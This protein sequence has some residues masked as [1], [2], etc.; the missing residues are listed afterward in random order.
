M[1]TIFTEYAAKKLNIDE[2]TFNESLDPNISAYVLRLLN[3]TLSEN[4]NDKENDI[5][6]EKVSRA[7]KIVG[8]I[9][10][11]PK[12]SVNIF[13]TT[14]RVAQNTPFRRQYSISTIVDQRNA[15]IKA[16]KRESPEAEM[17]PKQAKIQKTSEVMQ[18]SM[19]DSFDYEVEALDECSYMQKHRCKQ[20]SAS[21]EA[22]KSAV[23]RDSFDSS[24]VSIERE[25]FS[26]VEVS[27]L[28]NTS[29]NQKFQLPKSIIVRKLEPKIEMSQEFS[30]Q[31]VLNVPSIDESFDA[32]RAHSTPQPANVTMLDITNIHR[33]S[34]AIVP[35]RLV[36]EPETSSKALETD[37]P[38]W[39]SDFMRRYDSDM[40]RI[41][42][43]L[44]K[45]DR[46]LRLIV[47]GEKV[48]PKKVLIYPRVTQV[49]RGY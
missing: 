5:A 42:N 30:N 49:K 35:K 25:T 48:S 2:C 40:K 26:I 38:K 21:V 23:S 10:E 14:M 47:E 3:M 28:P 27:D 18:Q 45:I 7:E 17:W 11:M 31:S 8:K 36:Y 41:D 9:N 39:F 12:S 29:S 33:P 13:Q 1:F 20:S 24:C 19:G 4:A 44:E 6:L 34:N 32:F 16:A 43:K 46:T 15:S 37:P 22:E